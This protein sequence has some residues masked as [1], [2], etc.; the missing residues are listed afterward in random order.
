MRPAY[1]LVFAASFGTIL[2]G[3]A[4]AGSARCVAYDPTVVTLSG[5]L[6]RMTHA[7]PPNYESIKDGDAPETYL[8][9]R[10]ATPICTTD[11][12]DGING[13]LDGVTEVQLNLTASGYSGLRPRLGQRVT[14]SGKLY[15]AHSGHHYS[16]LVMG[17]VRVLLPNPSLERP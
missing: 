3:S 4:M 1:V 11:A 16:P 5:T 12:G 13:A 15:A 8:H 7:G 2:T 14:V 9:L 17:E 10:L 6:I